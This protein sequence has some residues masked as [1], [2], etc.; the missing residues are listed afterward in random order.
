MNRQKP[1]PNIATESMSISPA[2]TVSINLY[3]TK[4]VKLKILVKVEQEKSIRRFRFFRCFMDSGK[5]RP[6]RITLVSVFLIHWF[7][8]RLHNKSPH[9]FL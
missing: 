5:H 3:I 4:I 6:I 7:N 8:I 9:L 1:T 2:I